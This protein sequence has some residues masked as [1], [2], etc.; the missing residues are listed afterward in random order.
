MAAIV[1]IRI[2]LE[3]NVCFV[4]RVDAKGKPGLLRPSVPRAK[5]L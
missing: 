3:K 2:H 4:Y 5:L 1:T